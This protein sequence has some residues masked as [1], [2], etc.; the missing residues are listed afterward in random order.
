MDGAAG[1]VEALSE[2][3]NRQVQTKK[4]TDKLMDFA[5]QRVQERLV[6]SGM[7]HLNAGI[8]HLVMSTHLGTIDEQG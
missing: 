1:G 4:L 2:A 8:I 7:G 6:L 5:V 3:A